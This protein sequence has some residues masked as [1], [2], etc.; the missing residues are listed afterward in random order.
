MAVDAQTGWSTSNPWATSTTNP[1]VSGL[2]AAATPKP[3]VTVADPTSTESTPNPTSAARMLGTAVPEQPVSGTLS[4]M[5]AVQQAPSLGVSLASLGGM[6]NKIVN[7]PGAV[8][9]TAVTAVPGTTAPATP[10]PPQ[11]VAVP[12]MA[13]GGN[14]DGF[15]TLYTYDEATS[16]YAQSALY[17]S[18]TGVTT[19]IVGNQRGPQIETPQNITYNTQPLVGSGNANTPGGPKGGALTQA[20]SPNI[21]AYKASQASQQASDIAAG[22]N[23]RIDNAVAYMN[24]N[25]GATDPLTWR[26]MAPEAQ[27]QARAAY[28]EQQV[29][30]G[31][32]FNINGTAGVLPINTDTADIAGVNATNAITSQYNTN[33]GGADAGAMGRSAAFGRATQAGQNE[34]THDTAAAASFNENLTNFGNALQAQ[35]EIDTQATGTKLNADIQRVADVAAAL[36]QQVAAL[37][38]ATQLKVKGQINNLQQLV[39]QYNQAV[40]KY[41]SDVSW[42]MNLGKGVL[43][44]GAAIASVMT[45]GAAG[46]ALGTAA[47]AA[48]A[49]AK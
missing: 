32:L 22:R 12:M 29:A 24:A 15:W 16:S 1:L 10:A 20:Y 35:A 34:I 41:G 31:A 45:G 28:Q 27:A 48:G 49:A 2:A 26:L 18:N 4:Q 37:D 40:A 44:A 43:A 47:A 6:Q 30:N 23:A 38:T 14:S 42:V 46:V 39:N 9:P 25:G 21:D 3:T 19:S 36:E 13:G 11:T 17:N 8:A 7:L 33:L 5:P